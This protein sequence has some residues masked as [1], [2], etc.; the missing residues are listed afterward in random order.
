MTAPEITYTIILIVAIVILLTLYILG[1][2]RSLRAGSTGR[3]AAIP[4]LTLG[5]LLCVYLVF[6]VREIGPADWAQIVLLFGLVVVTGVYAMSTAR[7]ADASV[8]MAEEV[9]EQRITASRPLIIQKALY[10]KD[11]WEGNTRDYFSHFEISNVGS[12]P[13]IELEIS[14]MDAEGKKHS[15]RQT[16]LRSDDPPIKFRPSS[17][18]NLPESTTYYII[19]EYRSLYP[20]ETQKPWYQTRLPFKISKSSKEGAIYV[21]A[22]ELEFGAVSEKERVDAF[23][24][25]S[26]P[27]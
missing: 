6:N 12:S 9:R 19:S 24:S 23:S 26:K 22:G 17:I 5:F 11:T 13:A 10:D 27:K 3:R 2:I 20:A 25:R 8:K 4:V 21:V 16:F 18:A 15:I 14:F 1:L 7:Q